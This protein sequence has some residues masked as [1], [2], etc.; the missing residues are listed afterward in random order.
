MSDFIRGPL[1]DVNGEA[2]Q[3]TASTPSFS[4]VISSL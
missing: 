3:T 2:G 1:A 4:G